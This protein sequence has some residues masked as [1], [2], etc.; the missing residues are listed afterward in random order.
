MKN[1]NETEMINVTGGANGITSS[2]I[3]ALARL[4]STIY[5]LGRA[6]GSSIR[7]VYNGNT[8]PLN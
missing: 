7:R 8:C 1:L 3:N 2:A 5:T 4:V 6:I